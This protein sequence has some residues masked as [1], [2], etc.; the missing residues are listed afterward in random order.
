M[1]F[2]RTVFHSTVVLPFTAGHPYKKGTGLRPYDGSISG[3]ILLIS[4]I[5]VTFLGIFLSATIECGLRELMTKEVF[6][7][8]AVFI[9]TVACI[10][11]WVVSERK[12]SNI[13][14]RSHQDVTVTLKI[15]FLW[16]FTIGSIIYSALEI[17][18]SIQCDNIN[19]PFVNTF[20]NCSY[21]VN[22]PHKAINISFQSI[23]IVFY[24]IQSA[25]IHKFAAFQLYNSWKNYYSLLIIMFGN[26]S[27][28]AHAFVNVWVEHVPSA[29]AIDHTMSILKPI[30]HPIEM[31]Y[32]LL[33]MIFVAH[34]WP[35]KQ[36]NT[37]IDESFTDLQHISLSNETTPLLDSNNLNTNRRFHRF[38]ESKFNFRSMV[39]LTVCVL[40]KIPGFIFSYYSSDFAD[41]KDNNQSS[42]IQTGKLVH[43]LALAK[44]TYDV[45]LSLFM[46]VLKILC[47]YM[48]S[49][50]RYFTLKTHQPEQHFHDKI[51][52]VGYLGAI[53]YFSL[54]F[55]S[56][57][58]VLVTYKVQSSLIIIKN[59]AQIIE[60]YMQVV[61][62]LQLKHF[63]KSVK[64]ESLLI[65]TFFCLSI[66]NL[67]FWIED[68]AFETTVDT[69]RIFT[70][71]Y[72]EETYRLVS[73]IVFPI[74]IF[75]RFKSFIAYYGIFCSD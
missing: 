24:L 8:I 3:Y 44:F 10:G 36:P 40:I 51:I 69:E 12:P 21:S 49:Q 33:S 47:F 19:Q 64:Q 26:V 4:C 1:G 2:L 73:K 74:I 13:T 22:F 54:E 75:F 30:F 67:C 72:N 39:C 18:K 41:S 9:A 60:F 32:S 42:L 55:L 27:Q 34:L 11:I 58:F 52:V 59:T 70:Q 65:Y 57:I 56:C 17:M 62:I 63:H 35:E 61:C 5:L 66:L 31:E 14:L 29:C 15:A 25:F 37:S 38:R 16:I 43:P 7:C 50:Q 53:L 23:Q 68:S 46:I 6:L 28:W 48:V 45:T 20:K 71:V